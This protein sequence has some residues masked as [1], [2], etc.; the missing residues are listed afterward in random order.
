MGYSSKSTPTLNPNYLFENKLILN[1]VIFL[2]VNI[3]S[4]IIFLYTLE[5][6]ETRDIGLKFE[7]IFDGYKILQI[8]VK[9]TRSIF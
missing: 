6:G 7:Q 8:F 5:K 2:N 9:G 3:L 4:F 1:T